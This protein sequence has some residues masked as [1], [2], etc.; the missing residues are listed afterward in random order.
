MIT[1]LL[2]ATIMIVIY[3]LSNHI[4]DRTI[5][6]MSDK[7]YQ[8][9]TETPSVVASKNAGNIAVIK[10]QVDGTV[11]DIS[12]IKTELAK[13]R[14]ATEAN[15]NAMSSI[16]NQVTD[17][18]TRASGIPPGTDTDALIESLPKEGSM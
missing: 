1:W 4:F 6:S 10:E 3:N 7:K 17:L 9:Y 13:M 15:T 14:A 5:E 12:H 18:S 8:G 16:A 11:G 2:V